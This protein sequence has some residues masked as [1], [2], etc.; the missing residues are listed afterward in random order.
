MIDPILKSKMIE[1]LINDLD[2]K[3]VSAKIFNKLIDES[4]NYDSEIVN[5]SFQ[6]TLMIL[7]YL[8]VSK[9]NEFGIEDYV[10]DLLNFLIDK[11]DIIIHHNEDNLLLTTEFLGGRLPIKKIKR[12]LPERKEMLRLRRENQL[13]RS[14]GF[15]PR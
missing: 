1:V 9:M 4:I 6:M 15:K 8:D 3:E 2:N 13:N 11:S 12:N 10:D 5:V 7:N 14:S